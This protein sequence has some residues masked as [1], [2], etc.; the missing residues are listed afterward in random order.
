MVDRLLGQP[1]CSGAAGAVAAEV[2][3]VRAASA[4]RS[5]RP[6]EDA[7]LLDASAACSGRAAAA[8]RGLAAS[9]RQA[10]A[11]LHL[12]AAADLAAGRARS[13]GRA[14]VRRRLWP[15]SAICRSRR[16]AGRGRRG[17]GPWRARRRS[18]AGGNGVVARAAA[19]LVLAG[20]GLDP[21]PAR[22][23][24]SVTSSS[25]TTPTRWP[26]TG[27]VS[28][29]VSP[30]GC[31]TAC[32]A[33]E[34]GRA[35]RSRSPRRSWRGDRRR[36]RDRSTAPPWEA[37]SSAD[38]PGYQACTDTSDQVGLRPACLDCLSWLVAR[39]YPWS[40][41]TE[42]GGASGATGWR[43]P[44]RTPCLRCTPLRRRWEELD[45]ADLVPL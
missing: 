37:P 23:P 21:S 32:G 42:S 15:G 13:P 18:F 16:G 38:V 30:R 19:R 8:A 41:C 1:R 35:S 43:S 34:A 10:L 6:L 2:R 31:C 33:V 40:I 27:R 22:V 25:A 11:R 45:R 20:R 26:R 39:G 36:V 28:R 44:T 9:P 4:R 3:C 12:L 24:R 5:G 14:R 29:R 17:A 7:P